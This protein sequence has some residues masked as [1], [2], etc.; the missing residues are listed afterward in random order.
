VA[1]RDADV[2]LTE[3]E[4]EDHSWSDGV[5]GAVL[6]ALAGLPWALLYLATLRSTPT[7]PAEYPVLDALGFQVLILLQWPVYGFFYGYA[8]AL[9]RGSNAIFKALTVVVTAV[10]AVSL[11]T[12]LIWRPEDVRSQA[13]FALQML[14]FGL[15]LGGTFEISILRRDAPGFG[16]GD[17]VARRRGERCHHH[18]GQHRGRRAHHQS[19]Q[20]GQ[21]RWTDQRS[22]AAAMTVLVPD[23]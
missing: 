17:I 21:G 9:L 16:W 4:R 2:I 13:F 18:R 14:A 15:V 22:P 7:A 1:A 19:L 10:I 8:F 11:T 20:S 6:G 5:L 23:A 12:L 3:T